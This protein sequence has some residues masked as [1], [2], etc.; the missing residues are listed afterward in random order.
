[1]KVDPLY[2]ISVH[3]FTPLYEGNPR[4]LEIGVLVS[5]SDELGEKVCEGL[6]KRNHY[7]KVNEPY[8]GKEGL[9]A[10]D[11]LLYAKDPVRRQGVEFEFRNDLLLDPKKSEKI[12]ADTLEVVKE[13]CNL[14]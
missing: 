3:S 11:T 5:H 7:V 12:K 1:V 8:T 13:T 4:A 14:S 10:L 6:K 2:I 9:N